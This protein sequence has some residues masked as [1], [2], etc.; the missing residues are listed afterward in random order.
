[1]Y[2]L[3]PRN[4]FDTSQN[5]RVTSREIIS[6][7]PCVAYPN[8][9][10]ESF[11]NLRDEN[12]SAMSEFD[13]RKM[14]VGS[15]E[16]D[17]RFFQRFSSHRTVLRRMDTG[18]IHEARLSRDE[19]HS[20]SSMSVKNVCL[21]IFF[22]HN[23]PN[24]ECTAESYVNMT[25]DQ[26]YKIIYQK[27]DELQQVKLQL[28]EARMKEMSLGKSYELSIAKQNE[29]KTIN[30][31]LENL[32]T[33]LKSKKTH[34]MN[35]V[36]DQ[37]KLATCE[38]TAFKRLEDLSHSIRELRKT[39][40]SLTESPPNNQDKA[41][42]CLK[43]AV[44]RLIPYE[45]IVVS[46]VEYLKGER[47]Q[48]IRLMEDLSSNSHFYIDK[49]FCDNELKSENVKQVNI[50][51]CDQIQI[52]EFKLKRSNEVHKKKLCRIKN[53]VEA[54]ERSEGASSSPILQEIKNEANSAS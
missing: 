41:I 53:L 22:E 38:T 24:S 29:L 7:L 33:Q 32:V 40:S 4:C 18:H 13:M 34:Q 14:Q 28:N 20:P 43:A 54:L 6:G 11:I 2:P 52:L 44:G 51:L 3:S 16:L 36:A 19:K 30:S 8:S 17:S 42:D 46:E 50:S 9:S 10:N 48:L 1:M 15:S 27:H 45:E 5:S 37:L 25:R 12:D 49:H 47:Q 35:S 21:D 39:V 26:L 31:N 23:V